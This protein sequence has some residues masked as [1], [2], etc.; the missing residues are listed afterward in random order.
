MV[1]DGATGKVV[2]DIMDTPRVHGIAFAPKWNHGFTTNAGDSTVT[3]FNLSTL[4]VIKKIHA[5]IDGLDGIMYDDATDHILSINHSHPTGTAVVIDANS[6]DVLGT[7]TLSGGAP[8]G[9][10]SD[11]Q[12][13]IFINIEDKNSIDVIDAKTMKVVGN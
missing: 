13:R 10:A 8:E 7:I 1:V 9:G 12:G 5:G 11:G 6:G 2:G 4:A 3:M